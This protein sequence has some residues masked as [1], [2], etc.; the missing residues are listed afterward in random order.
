MKYYLFLVISLCISCNSNTE[1]VSD[2][3]LSET[4]FT[5]ILKEIH[6]AE[7]TFELQKNKGIKEAENELIKS[8]KNIYNTYQISEEDF[9]NTLAFYS[10]NPEELEQIYTHVLELL[11][12]ENS[13]LDQQ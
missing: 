12:N 1:N 11:N 8:Y 5:N 10:K 6:L 7:A 9:K 4:I 13:K 3:I 2:N